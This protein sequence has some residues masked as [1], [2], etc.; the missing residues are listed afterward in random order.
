M[1]SELDKKWL[2]Q[3]YWQARFE[4]A[5]TPWQLEDVSPV[6]TE[7]LDLLVAQGVSLAGLTALSPGCG[8][9]LDAL[10]CARRELDVVAVD[11]SH[12]AVVDL[13]SRCNALQGALRGTVKVVEGDLFSIRPIAVD[14]VVEHTFFCAID[15]SSRVRY[16]KKLHEWLKPGGFVVGN[17]FVVE[18]SEALRLPD[19]SLTQEGIGPPFAATTSELL[20]L[21]QDGFECVALRPAQNPTPGRRTAL[22]WIGLFRRA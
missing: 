5:D 19:L 3:T 4:N 8:T 20:S 14:L 10:E 22:E 11:W 15:P 18:E 21:F 6:V 17:F 2:T 7:A 16:V 1:N 13:T 9:G 12:A